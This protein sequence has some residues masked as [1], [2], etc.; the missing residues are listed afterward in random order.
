MQLIHSCTHTHINAG[1]LSKNLV[2]LV[3]K[4]F[5]FGLYISKH[6]LTHIAPLAITLKASDK[7][8]RSDRI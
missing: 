4:C 2:H 5:V 8:H 7:E 1:D 3:H 6:A